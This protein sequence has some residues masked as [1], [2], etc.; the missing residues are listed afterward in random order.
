MDAL[1]VVTCA[2]TPRGGADR[3]NCREGLGVIHADATF[4]PWGG[5]RRRHFSSYA[6]RS[7]TLP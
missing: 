3:G 2:E 6:I 7:E 4:A 1:D 5:D